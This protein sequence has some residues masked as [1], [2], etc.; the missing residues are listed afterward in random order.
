M[1]FGTGVGVGVGVGVGPGVG[2]G[3]GVGSGGVGVD[4]DETV[5]RQAAVFEPSSAVADIIASPFALAVTT[6][7]SSTVATETLSLSHFNVLLV[8]LLG[9]IVA[10]N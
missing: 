4:V 10:I 1:G 7:V 6:P 3:V 8:A 9:V 5:T 2:I